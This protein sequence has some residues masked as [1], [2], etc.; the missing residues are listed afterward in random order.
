MSDADHLNTLIERAERKGDT[1]KADKH[2]G[3][4]DGPDMPEGAEYLVQMFY[5]VGPCEYN[6]VG[7][8]PLSF[9]EI[10]SWS[11][12]TKNEL[13]PW[14]ATLLKS[15]SRVYCKVANERGKAGNPDG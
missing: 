4:L 12:L 1:A 14:E 5:E 13:L 9:K 6:G 7:S 2:R 10:H 8:I 3:E 15:L 11:M